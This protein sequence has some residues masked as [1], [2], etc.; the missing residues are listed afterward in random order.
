MTAADNRALPWTYVIDEP[1]RILVVDDDPILLEFASVHLSMPCVTVE[2]ACDGAAARDRLAQEAFDIVVLD[3]EMPHVDGLTLLA[4]IR[5]NDR[6][7]HLPVVMLTGREDIGSIDRAY[8]IGADSFSTKPVNWR[9]LSYHLRYVI[10]ASRVKKLKSS[11]SDSQ[12]G[13]GSTPASPVGEHDIHDFLRS[14]VHQANTLEQQLSLHDRGRW[15]ELL[16]SLRSAAERADGEYSDGAAGAATDADHQRTF[17]HRLDC[18]VGARALSSRGSS[19]VT[20]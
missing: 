6:L 17:A 4:E 13:A 14:I 19:S 11:S 20:D 5:A 1:T 3:I 12:S 15:S 2:T 8:Q 7:K 18:D 9:Q 10:R 16:D